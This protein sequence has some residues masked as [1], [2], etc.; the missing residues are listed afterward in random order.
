ME[1]RVKEIELRELWSRYKKRRREGAR[2]T[3]AR[4][5]AAREVRR[6]QDV[7]RPSGAH[8]GGRPDLVRPARADRRDRALRAR[9]RDQVRDFRGRSDQG[10]DHRRAALARLGAALGA[11]EGARD[12]GRARRSSSGSSGVRRPTRR[13]PDARDVD[14]R[15]PG[16][17]A[18]DLE[19]LASSRSTSCGRSPTPAATRSRSSTRCSDPNAVDPARELGVSELKD[20]LAHAI[21]RAA[22]AGE[23]RRRALLLREPDPARDRRGP[24]RDRVTRLPASHEGRLAPEGPASERSEPA[25]HATRIS[26][27]SSR[28]RRRSGWWR[29]KARSASG[30]SRSSVIAARARLAERGAA[31]R[32]RRINRLGRSRTARPSPTREPDEVERELSISASLASFEYED[33]KINLIDTPGEPSFVADTLALSGLRERGLRGQWGD[34]RRGD[35]RPALAAGDELGLARLVFVNML[36]RERADFFRALDSLKEAFGPARRRDGD[37]DRPGARDPRR[38]RP[39]RHEGLRIRGRRARERGKEIEIPGRGQRPGGRPTARS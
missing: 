21:S 2:T 25:V 29:T 38:R 36:D 11:R 34:G 15:L 1:T 31:V 7:E 3:C 4:L 26:L 16:Q 37:P 6:G 10:L 32:G 39:D 18:P 12:R 22:G 23:A 8:R 5:L 30:M 20:R 24:R 19:L 27:S 14:G 35:D 17:P 13:S 28:S 33:R 9:A